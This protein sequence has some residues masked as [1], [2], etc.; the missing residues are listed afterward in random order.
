MK[1]IS[2]TCI[3][4]MVLFISGASGLASQKKNLLS[5]LLYLEVCN[6]GTYLILFTATA[7]NTVSPALLMVFLCLSVCEASVGLAV[8]VMMARSH[9]N[10]Y[11]S[12]TGVV[13]L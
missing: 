1:L 4:G 3:L 7:A 11:V 13:A 10:D 9:G 2:S 6:L 12:T 5:I 8:L